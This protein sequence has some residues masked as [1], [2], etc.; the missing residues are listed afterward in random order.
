MH[1][2]VLGGFYDE[3][4]KIAGAVAPSVVR[5]LARLKASKGMGK[6][7]A[8]GLHNFNTR[9]APAVQ[10]ARVEQVM[11]AKKPGFLSSLFN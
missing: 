6:S 2:I 8:G 9:L 4:E 1:G 11:A 5:D 7:L 10:K 3:L